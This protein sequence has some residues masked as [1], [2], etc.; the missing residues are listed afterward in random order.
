MREHRYETTVVWT[1]NTGEG[2]ANYRAYTRDLEARGDGLPPI[3]SSSD[4]AFRGD[5]ER[6]NPELL[7][8]SA[9]SQCHMLWHLHLCAT[10]GVVVVAYEDRAEGT[11]AQTDDGGGHFTEVVLRPRV[12]VADASMT[13][14]AQELHEPAHARCFIAQSMNFPVRHEPSV[15]VA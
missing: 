8:V 13:A 14:K 7:L 3:P 10:G 6:W 4:P 5:P 11:M 12:T 15:D 2:T 9:L 1:G